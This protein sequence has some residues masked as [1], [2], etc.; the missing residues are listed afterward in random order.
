MAFQINTKIMKKL[1]LFLVLIGG[2]YSS[3]I[4]A[5]NIS[6]I[7]KA[8]GDGNADALMQHF[9]N[10][11]EVAILDKEDVLNRN[12]AVKVV[13]DFFARNR[14]SSFSQMHQGSS[15][16]QDSQFVIGNL[17]TSGGTYRVYIYMKVTG[18]KYLVQELR[19]DK[20]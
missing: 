10:T 7:T 13:R 20:G 15:K 4:E 11:V 8:I 18:G 3:G 2:V 17:S 12:D 1:L 9:D 14:T 16:G 5:Q 19:F 6:A